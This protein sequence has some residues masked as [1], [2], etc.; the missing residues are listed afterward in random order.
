VGKL[1]RVGLMATSLPSALVAVLLLLLLLGAATLAD[2]ETVLERM[3]REKAAYAAKTATTAGREAWEKS[4]GIGSSAPTGLLPLVKAGDIAA[5]RSL[6]AT[7][8]SNPDLLAES[9][10]M[11]N[12]VMHQTAK[13]MNNDVALAIGQMLVELNPTMNVRNA[14]WTTA[15]SPCRASAM[16]STRLRAACQSAS[17]RTM[18]KMYVA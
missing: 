14:P 2:A 8:G 13:I 7:A 12:G 6:L 11:Q 16:A 18:H 9:D 3:R 1:W 5:V 17:R 4:N 15:R 10:R